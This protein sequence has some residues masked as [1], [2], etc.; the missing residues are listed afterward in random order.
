[1]S[2]F[3]IRRITHRLNGTH[4]FLRKDPYM[5]EHQLRQQRSTALALLF[6]WM[7]L[8]A[9]GG[10]E[11]HAANPDTALQ[12]IASYTFG[13]S[14]EALSDVEDLVRNSQNDPKERLRLEK[15][16]ASMLK[17]EETYDCKD[18]ICRQLRLIGTKESV[19]SLKTLLMEEETSDMARYALL[20]IP[21]DQAGKALRDGLKKAKGKILIG[22]INTLGERR[23]EECAKRLAQYI[24]D[25]AKLHDTE[26][27]DSEDEEAKKAMH[28]AR[29][30]AL[31][32]INA[33]AKIGGENAAE[34]LA[35]ARLISC[36]MVNKAATGAL[37][38]WADEMQ[39]K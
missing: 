12:K 19:P 38:L 28:E 8:A 34:T 23:D 15:K 7:A 21:G 39:R 11:V 35:K 37:L 29:N 17:S 16:L 1:M 36:P 10:T 30:T 5:N 14:R 22:I 33:L 9:V 4:I 25:F 32:A 26:D 31:A 18:F 20:Y 24:D 3:K 27:K 2:L 13:E 6:V